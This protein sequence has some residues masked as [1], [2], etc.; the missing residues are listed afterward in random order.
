MYVRCLIDVIVY[1]GYS[2]G[3]LKYVPKEELQKRGK[4]GAL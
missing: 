4:P 3:A 2:T 1:R